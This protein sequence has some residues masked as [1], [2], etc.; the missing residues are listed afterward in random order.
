VVGCAGSPV[1]I[2]HADMT[3]TQ[4]VSRGDNCQPASGAFILQLFQKSTLG[5]KWCSF[6]NRLDALPLI[7]IMHCKE[8]LMSYCIYH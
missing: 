1:C 7:S 5:D 3:L 8:Q 2:V 4:S 6:F